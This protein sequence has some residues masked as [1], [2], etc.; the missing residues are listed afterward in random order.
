[1][2][3]AQI[4]SGFQSS[5][6]F[7]IMGR[8]RAERLPRLLRAT[9][10]F[11]LTVV[12]ACKGETTNPAAE[13]AVVQAFI[14][15]SI[16][17]IGE[18]TGATAITLDGAGRVVPDQPIVWSSSHPQVASVNA[19]GSIT[20]LAPGTT[21]I[22]G[23]SGQASG[24]V[25]LTVVATLPN[26]KVDYAYLLQVVQRFGSTVPLIAGGNP[27]LVR[28]FGRLDRPMPRGSRP[29]RV[30]VE[31][32]QNGT[33]IAID[34]REMTNVAATATSAIHEVVMPSPMPGLS[35]R[36][37]VNPDSSP[38][39]ETL[40]DNVFPGAGR[41][42]AVDVR[43]MQPLK[44]HF[45]PL[46]MFPFADGDPA[47]IPE[48]LPPAY[49]VLP[50][51][52]IDV[53]VGQRLSTQW[54]GELGDR[55]ALGN[56]LRQVDV[57]RLLEGSRAYWVALMGAGAGF[58]G[59]GF[60]GTDPT[61]FGPNTHVVGLRGWNL[62]LAHELG[63]NMARLHAPCANPADD[64]DLNYPYAG[65]IANISGADL[66]TWSINGTF[67][68]EKPPSTF[69]L[70][71]YCGPRWISDYT[72]E[73]FIKWR[74]SEDSASLAARDEPQCDCLIVWGTV[75]GDSIHLDPSFVARTRPALP[76][77]SGAYSLSGSDAR[78]TALFSLSFDPARLDHDDSRPFLFAIPLS[79][80]GRSE[81]T[82]IAVAGEGKS[83][84]R[85]RAGTAFSLRS[86]LDLASPRLAAATDGRAT[87]TW[88]TTATPLLIARDPLTGRVLGISQSGR[89]NVAT[90][91][92]RLNVLLSD[93]IRSV[94]TTLVRQ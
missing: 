11:W 70:M 79:A 77:K 35:F 45:V 80:T 83:K 21:T 36:V 64:L 4:L 86:P 53:T 2:W 87:I 59:I 60:L 51:S 15:A 3:P 44:L 74:T 56:V 28:V 39:E 16:I 33:P 41:T 24:Q 29:P 57:V 12:V 34:E 55:G 10:T 26:I 18:Q 66:Y 49:Q 94:E 90:S 9:G 50:V 73:A 19:S 46:V 61:D 71:S 65:G 20:G 84:V 8:I 38:P 1:M 85:M 89:M 72:Y 88:D 6:K 42:H 43:V 14:S 23:T 27:L 75:T 78:G 22:T 48:L 30:R 93:G 37:T 91:S 7:P 13:V 31:F 69:D 62:T 40:A 76:R 81:L 68:A 54:R 92:E 32:F 47:L 67:P 52:T 58:S 17:G 82:R 25:S 5:S 63:H